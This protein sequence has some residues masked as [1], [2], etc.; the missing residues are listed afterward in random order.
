MSRCYDKGSR[1]Y[2]GVGRGY[3]ADMEAHARALIG[4]ALEKVGG[5]VGAAAAVLGLPNARC[6]RLA[7]SL[8]LIADEGANDVG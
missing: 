2:F 1:F 4:A 6:R 3:D 5:R 8:G 7:V